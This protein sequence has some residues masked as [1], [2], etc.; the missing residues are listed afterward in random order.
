MLKPTQLLKFAFT[1]TLIFGLG[2]YSV[3]Q[4]EDEYDYSDSEDYDYENS[5]DGDTDYSGNDYSNESEDNS[6]DYSDDYSSGGSNDFF[7][8]STKEEFV[9]RKIIRKPYVRFVPPYDSL[10]ELVIYNAVVEVKDRDGFETEIDTINFRTRQWLEAEFGKD[11]KK[12]TTFDDINENASELEYKIKIHAAFPCEIEPN[13]FTKVQNGMV[14][15][16][17]EIRVR[18]GRYRWVIQNLV[19]VAQPRPG[20]KEG[21]RTYF[22]YLMK[23]EDDIRSGDKVLIAADKKINSMMGDLQKVCQTN[24]V[25][26]EDEW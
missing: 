7:G 15:Y 10:R 11:L 13:E 17:M 18:D 6:N 1:G 23:A 21:E 4:T 26:E 12:V 2:F 3:G 5:Y 24:P 16:D 25:E 8:G 20:E 14:E 19:H 22:E 9:P